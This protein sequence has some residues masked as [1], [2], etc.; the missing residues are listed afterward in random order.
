VQAAYY[1][2]GQTTPERHEWATIAQWAWGLSRA[3]DYLVRDAYIDPA[4]I[5]VFGHSRNG[6]TALVAAAFDERIALAPRTRPAAA[7]PR[8]AGARSA[9]R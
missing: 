7:A 8:R 9:S 2:P 6:K 5:A 4:R 1:R 3:V